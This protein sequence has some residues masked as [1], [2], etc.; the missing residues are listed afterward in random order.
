M[1]KSYYEFI[2]KDSSM[3]LQRM[4]HIMLQS[5]TE[6]GIKEGLFRTGKA[7]IS[8][9]S[10]YNKLFPSMQNSSVLIEAHRLR[11]YIQDGMEKEALEQIRKIKTFNDKAI[12]S[13]LNHAFLLAVLHKMPAVIEA[14]FSRGFPRSINSRIFGGK[15]STV[16]P[17][18]FL[19]SLATQ[20]LSI[21]MVF[22]RR[23]VDYHETW[24]GIGPVHLAAVNSDIRVLDMV[25]THGG[26]PME[27]TTSL[28]YSLL[29]S[30]FKKQDVKCG[31]QGRPIYPVDIAAV[32]NNWGCFLLLMD[33]SPKCAAYSQHLLHI[34]NSL[35]MIIKAINIGA[36]I[37]VPLAD[38]S[39][40]LHTKTLQNRPEIVSFY[41]ALSL[42][43]EAE[44]SE[45]QTPLSL[46]LHMQ[47]KE[48]AWI[49]V[50]SGAKVEDSLRA[51][52]VLQEIEAGWAPSD[53]QQEKFEYYKHA[54]SYAEVVK[55]KPKSRFS[56]KRIITRE[57]STIESAVNKL[58]QKIE[59]VEKDAM[60]EFKKLPKEELYEKFV[61]AIERRS[62]KKDSD[63]F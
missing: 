4:I 53:A 40:I 60:K 16:F 1:H 22:L 3:S 39:T 25:L 6:R 38:R 36:R 48:V 57:E 32:A 18:Y 41:V 56:I 52:P 37:D 10:I 15:E 12:F 5:L 46:A 21:I 29:H 7:D 2:E 33:K 43:L 11:I 44:N 27:V 30:L 63:D 8:M 49:L 9:R 34:L 14:F 47:H 55:H 20:S 17:T 54:A 51:H 59:K 19:L 23:S 42:P 58:N 45:G 61:K 13:L 62:A 24:H 50:M 31:M 35:E 28:Q 26:N